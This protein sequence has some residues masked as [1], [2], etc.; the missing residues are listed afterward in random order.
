MPPR[1]GRNVTCGRSADAGPPRKVFT[2]L[3]IGSRA[4]LIRD[5]LPQSEPALRND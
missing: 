2:K 3:G 4:D 5:G 1:P